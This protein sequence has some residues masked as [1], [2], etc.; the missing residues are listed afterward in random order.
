MFKNFAEILKINIKDK[1]ISEEIIY[2]CKH[3]LFLKNYILKFPESL[4]KVKPLLGKTRDKQTIFADLSQ[5]DYLKFTPQQFCSFLRHKKMEEY[6][7][8]A[9]NDIIKNIDVSETTFHLSS[10]A[11]AILELTYK[12]AYNQLK[13][14]FGT[15]RNN[16]GDEVPFAIIGLGKLGGEELNFSSDIDIIYVYGTEKGFTDGKKKISN[17]EFFVKLGEKIFHYLSDRDEIGIVFRVDLRLRPD[18]EKG[19]LAL[20][21]RSYEIY[22]ETYGQSWERMMLLKANPVAGNID[23]GY[24]FL[25]T[26][27]PFVFRRTLDTKLINDL[28]EIKNKIQRR[29][30]LK[31]KN[32][33]NVKLGFGGIRE[34]EFIV[35]ALQIL[36]YPKHPDIFHRNTLKALEKLTE[37]KLLNENDSKTLTNAYKFLRKLEHMTQI[38]NE[39][40]THTIPENSTTFHLYLERCGFNTKEEF[41]SRYNEITSSV[42]RIF[43]KLLE[44]K[45]YDETAV[46]FD[47]ELDIEDITFY[48]KSKNIKKPEKCAKIIKQ[49]IRGNRYTPRQKDEK[50]L[51]KLFFKTIIPNLYQYENPDE[52]L[53]FYEKLFLRR[54]NLYLIYDLGL[55]SPHFLQKLTNLFAMSKHLS[56]IALNNPNTLEFLYDPISPDYTVEKILSLLKDTIN[57]KNI[58]EELEYELLRLKQK[59]YIFNIGYLYLNK[60]INIVQAMY[61][62]TNIARAFTILAFE[63]SFKKLTEKYGSPITK[64]KNISD[65]LVVGLGKLGSFEI[66]F[67]SDLDLIILYEDNGFTDGPKKITNRE[68]FS[69]LVQKAIH[70]LSTMTYNGYLYKVDMR[71]RPS[72]SS[73]TLVTTIKSFDE[74][75]KKESMTWE[76]QALLRADVINEQSSLTQLFFSIKNRILFTKEVKINQLQEIYDM[77]MRIEKEKGS[78]YNKNDFKAGYGGLIDIEFIA[79]SFQLKYGYTSELLKGTNTHYILHFLKDLGFITNRNF[80]ALHNSYLFLRHIENL[81]RVYQNLST[82]KLPNDN[83]LLAQIGH[84]FG[85]KKDAHEKII[86]DFQSVRKTVR[87]AFNRL[88]AELLKE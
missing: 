21:L 17:H 24:Q 68:F 22:Y 2:L 85:Y 15:P 11:C 36:N 10:F 8:I 70:Y 87:G 12:F 47:E 32:E 66:S 48:L 7:I 63:R 13:N 83:N 28:I 9:Y 50:K 86:S 43:S 29:V 26:V 58:D 71:L 52:I 23:F 34:I 72:G 76:K 27:K 78:P 31:S 62:L 84:F 39:L 59:E 77:R 19:P 65:Y 64:N 73:G 35:Q 67:G 33:K 81:T 51:L 5:T 3:S 45:D 53:N 1:N 40:Q 18:G 75:H 41:E 46:L 54:S 30:D 14:N 37:K 49:I 61:S 69:K 42:N 88:F 16:A 20:P 56:E 57:K 55:E 82:S 79:Q 6:I 80:Y 25:E 38:E 60:N 44:N 74:Y 4:L